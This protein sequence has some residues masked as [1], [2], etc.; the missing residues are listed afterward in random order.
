MRIFGVIGWKNSGKTHLMVRLVSEITSRGFTVSTIKHAHHSI[1][2]TTLDEEGCELRPPGVQEA[3]FASPTRWSLVRE[4]LADE[5]DSLDELVAR[6]QPV[7][8]VLIEGYKLEHH[9][10]IE[11][12]RQGSTRDLI[13]R[14]DKKIVGIA[15]DAPPEGFDVP[16]FDL[17]DT[18]GIADFILG[19]VGL[20]G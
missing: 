2:F 12:Y 10:K 14:E 7:D 8:L 15:T 3:V 20:K 13:A 6:L 16:V 5:D 18:I 9:P 4:R 11:A 17:N 19:Y 1:E